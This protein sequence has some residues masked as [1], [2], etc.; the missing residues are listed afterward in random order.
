MLHFAVLAAW[1]VPEHQYWIR[2]NTFIFSKPFRN[3][4]HLQNKFVWGVHNQKCGHQS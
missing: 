4:L 1:E 2:K 3:Y